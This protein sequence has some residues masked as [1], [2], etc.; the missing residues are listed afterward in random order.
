MAVTPIVM[1]S[2]TIYID[3]EAIPTSS[4]Y[5]APGGAVSNFSRKEEVASSW[6]D[7]DDMYD[8]KSSCNINVHIFKSVIQPDKTDSDNINGGKVFFTGSR[9]QIIDT[10]ES[11]MEDVLFVQDSEFKKHVNGITTCL[12]GETNSTLGIWI[13]TTDPSTVD[14]CIKYMEDGSEGATCHFQKHKED[15]RR[16]LFSCLVDDEKPFAQE[17]DDLYIATKKSNNDKGFDE[18]M[19]MVDPDD[20]LQQYIEAEIELSPSGLWGDM[21]DMNQCVMFSQVTQLQ[22]KLRSM[23]KM[24]QYTG[25][26]AACGARKKIGEK[27]AKATRVNK[28]IKTSFTSTEDTSRTDYSDSSETFISGRSTAEVSGASTPNEFAKHNSGRD[29]LSPD[30]LPPRREEVPHPD[31]EDTRVTIELSKFNFKAQPFKRK[32]KKSEKSDSQETSSAATE[33]SIDELSSKLNA[34][35]IKNIKSFVPTKRKSEP[36]KEK[37]PSDELKEVHNTQSVKKTTSQRH[38]DNSDSIINV[39]S[40][41]LDQ[42][43]AEA[44]HQVTRTKT[45]TKKTERT[46]LT[47]SSIE[48]ETDKEQPTLKK[49]KK[50]KTITPT[51]Y[52]DMLRITVQNTQSEEVVTEP[53]HKKKSVKEDKKLE[54]IP[55]SKPVAK[56][57]SSREE[58][59][60][61]LP[62][63]SDSPG[64]EKPK[65]NTSLL[66]R[67]KKAGAVPSQ[68][69]S[70]GESEIKVEPM[71]KKRS[72]KFMEIEKGPS[73]VAQERTIISAKTSV[74]WYVH[75]IQKFRDSKDDLINVF[76]YHT[77]I[78]FIVVGVMVATA[79]F[80]IVLLTISNKEDLDD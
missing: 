27:K 5:S 52:E 39:H 7:C 19:E 16:T 35:A 57:A 6:A 1:S 20:F 22:V 69:K 24:L 43:E 77:Q 54:Q 71:R 56:K 68:K 62:K 47:E 66:K 30:T 3:D 25:N 78:C 31:S 42:S 72:S 26:M 65:K 12:K 13:D 14:E 34:E 49:K 64:I 4:D 80:I 44:E 37:T 59:V 28:W 32:T 40:L 61:A 48:Q 74:P 58:L 73:D 17:E 9:V 45:K 41:D 50:S 18:L 51:K 36:K 33:G 60:K 63:V 55:V 29:I 79:S 2:Y 76:R 38:I 8:F 53:I 70:Y 75:F 67:T 46:K 15:N 10:I 21:Y 23:D 11:L